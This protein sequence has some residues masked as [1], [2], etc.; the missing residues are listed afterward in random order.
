MYRYFIGLFAILLIGVGGFYFQSSFAQTSVEGLG[1]KS[2]AEFLRWC[3]SIDTNKRE[4]C[5]GY[6]DGVSYVWRVV[7]ACESVNNTDLSFCSGI[8]AARRKIQNLQQTCEDCDYETQKQHD[9]DLAEIVGK[10]TPNSQVSSSY[11]EGFNLE[12]KMRTIDWELNDRAYGL[13]QGY[14]QLV[15]D[16]MFP[17]ESDYIPNYPCIERD[18]ESRTLIASIDAFADDYPELLQLH[19]RTSF[20]LTKALFY[21]LCPGPTEHLSPHMEHCSDW[22]FKGDDLWVDNSCGE[23]ISIRFQADTG[24]VI[25]AKIKPEERFSPGLSSRKY[26]STACLPGYVSSVPFSKENWETISNSY[27]HCVKE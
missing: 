11:C 15:M 2:S 5:E 3:K 16:L 13:F 14:T 20:F 22:N 23:T 27:Y 26:I 21:G 24:P 19:S 10:C 4:F 7:T 9:Q 17:S 12:V 18:A 1:P 8:M 6:I 25:E